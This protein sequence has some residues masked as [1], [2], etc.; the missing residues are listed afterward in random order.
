MV[1]ASGAVFGLIGAATRLM[2]VPPGGRLLRLTDRRVVTAS[3]AWMGVNVLTGV[4]GV[5]P[6]VDGAGIAWEAHAVGFVF[7]LLAIGPIA[8][9]A[10]RGAASQRIAG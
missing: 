5:M 9:L 8:R 6:G 2:G 1:G 7:G 3:I 10:G 4:I